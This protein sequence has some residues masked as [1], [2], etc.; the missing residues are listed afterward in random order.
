MARHSLLSKLT[1][2]IMPPIQAS[3]SYLGLP[4]ESQLP[5]EDLFKAYEEDI[6][7]EIRLGGVDV[8]EE[9]PSPREEEPTDDDIDVAQPVGETR[10]SNFFLNML[11][12]ASVYAGMG[13]VRNKHCSK[14][15]TERP[16]Q[17][18]H[19]QPLQATPSQT[20]Y[21]PTE[22]PAIHT[23]TE[24]PAEAPTAIHSTE[25][26]IHT[27][28]HPGHYPTKTGPLEE[29]Q[30]GAQNLDHVNDLMQQLSHVLE[31]SPSPEPKSPPPNYEGLTPFQKSMLINLNPQ[32]D[33]TGLLVNVKN[34]GDVSLL[35]KREVLL[36]MADKLQ[37]VFELADDDLFIR[38][39]DV[40]LVHDVLLQGHLYVTRDSLL[41]FAF[42][43]KR[44]APA[45]DQP[46]T[47]DDSLA[48]I[49]SGSLGMKTAQYGDL[50]FST[51]LTHRFWAILRPET[52]TIYRS[53][54]D[55]YFPVF[56]IDLRT[57]VKA[58]IV[59]Q[60]V[61]PKPR[62]PSDG[63]TSPRPRV[64]KTSSFELDSDL[65][66]L[67]LD[68]DEP[69]Q[70]TGG[71]WFRLVT[72][73]KSYRFHTDNLYSA[74]QWVNLL[75]KTIFS[76]QNANDNS[77]V[78]IKIP[79][80]DVSHFSRSLVLTSPDDDLDDPPL[81][82]AVKYLQEHELRV[83]GQSGPVSNNIFFLF[84]RAGD[85]FNT[86]MNELLQA[87]ANPTIVERARRARKDKKAVS[88]L[89]SNPD[90]T[91]TL[92]GQILRAN[93]RDT[94]PGPASQVE[95]G[96][97]LRKI[98]RLFTKSPD[99]AE[100]LGDLPHLETIH[101]PRN[102]SVNSLKNLN[103][104]FDVSKRKLDE[105]RSR[106][107]NS[108][109]AALP[110]LHLS[111]P[112]AHPPPKKSKMK[113]LGKTIKL[114]S[115]S[116]F[117]VHPT[118]YHD[119]SLRY[120]EANEAARAVAL[121][122]FRDHFSLGSA[123]VLVA[124]YYGHLCRLI[125]VYGK[126]YLGK[127][128]ICFRSLLPG[129]L[130]KMILPLGEVEN[131]YEEPGPKLKYLGLVIVV[132]GVSDIL[133]EF[134]SAS[135]R[136]DCL[137]VL[138]G[139]LD[140]FHSNEVWAP[141]P[142]EWGHNY[143]VGKRRTL[144]E[145]EEPPKRI[146]STASSL[147]LAS[148]RIEN[149]RIKLFED[150]LNA[151][152]GLDFPIILEDL[153]F[154]KT[155]VRPTTSYNFTLL[156]IG[157]RGDVQPYIALA[158]GLMA[159]GHNVTIAT[160]SEFKEWVQKHNIGFREIAG[161]PTE[162]MSLMVEHGS[163]LVGFLKEA[164]LRFRS[165]INDLLRLSW[166]A[167]Q[168]TDILIESP[169]AM[170]GIHIAEAL[171]I[172]YM[173]AFTMPWTR[174]R[175]YPHAFIV[176]DQRKGGSYN[177]LTHVMFENVFWKGISTQ[178]NRWRVEELDLPRTSLDKLQQLK[179]PFLYN[180]LPTIFPPLVDFPDWVRVTG[181]WFLDEGSADTYEPPEELAQ[182]LREADDDDKKVVYIGFGLIVVNDAKSLTRAV[183]DAV[184]QADVRC[185]LNR[186]WLDRL[187]RD[188]APADELPAEVYDAGAIPHDWLFRRIHAAV[189]H[190]GLGTTGA[191]VRF[192][193]PTVIK[194]F[195]GDQFFYAL[196]IEE[197][198]MGVAIKNLNAKSLAKALVTVT[199]DI[200]IIEKAEKV[201]EQ[202]KHE[203]GV[204]TAVETIYS[205]L[206]YARNLILAKREAN[207]MARVH[208]VKSGTQTPVVYEESE[209]LDYSDS[210]ESDDERSE[211][212][213]QLGH[214]PSMDSVL[215]RD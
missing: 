161:N 155:E 134:G 118:H 95:D 115:N 186:G 106:Y 76:L 8:P 30:L 52:L 23:S 209:E 10:P 103:M 191:S 31:K 33:R 20:F 72:K 66:S 37:L 71:V 81:A 114:L 54:T 182:F 86:T 151:A 160:H 91:L 27:P 210:D 194:P 83:P 165:W 122:H 124:S 120:Y 133:M 183:V 126:V 45:L 39:Y 119:P 75:S 59:E 113:S 88:T 156:T 179:V 43:P 211:S 172:P 35:H 111:E 137:A 169:L 110:V 64:T 74:R 16:T 14:Q 177:Y 93:Q 61:L 70:V 104:T 141:K 98:R 123:N 65:E 112:P 28:K 96:P 77:E 142:H 150:K 143:D 87:K 7:R 62:S 168:G 173:R 29:H 198:G 167:C 127:Q 131:C 25:S 180:V 185:I 85:H 57:A 47:L 48:T 18:T 195:F 136:D 82:F 187:A 105:A 49:H 196:R 157:S 101:L 153:P 204:S 170:G 97:R 69:E 4:L 203:M 121:E 21:T 109:S 1:L 94:V 17:T 125:P 9:V 178:V 34:S 189:H 139:L 132:R 78:L 130:T 3:F 68:H 63:V 99:N 12:T 140:E 159:E 116:F 138:L 26:A 117:T 67:V 190:G 19:T 184:L 201:S 5:Y 158:K 84:L 58:H 208:G 199:S 149:A 205:E 51:V 215:A 147:L 53:T 175:A 108:E 200:R 188:D 162:L 164:S 129:V 146:A 102:F 135:A 56:V 41:F 38:N 50:Y 42:L 79:I 193:L 128:Q 6:E 92:V 15:D 176:P 2:A 197:I 24:A 174:T 89:A 100:W 213:D 148:S 73:K 80:E 46:Y 22:T 202:V 212:Y 214:V 55:L 145:L 11:T 192:G 44:R 171:G 144:D 206:E 40:W 154:F 90:T 107:D 166:E 207:E 152:A 163:M 32:V 60:P 181:Y 36:K 13:N